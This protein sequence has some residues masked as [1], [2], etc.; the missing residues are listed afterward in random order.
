MTNL[1]AEFDQIYC[2]EVCHDLAEFEQ[3]LKQY[4]RERLNFIQ[5][6]SLQTAGTVFTRGSVSAV[7]E[8]VKESGIEYRLYD[9]DCIHVG[10]RDMS[11]LLEKSQHFCIFLYCYIVVQDLDKFVRRLILIFEVRS[12]VCG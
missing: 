9:I 12:L 6:R 8:C 10:G 2:Q 3:L 11:V 5:T 7:T 4:E 1:D